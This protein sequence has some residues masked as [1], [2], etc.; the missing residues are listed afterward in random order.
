MPLSLLLAVSLK[1][2]GLLAVNLSRSFPSQEATGQSAWK[3]LTA[4]S[5]PVAP[6]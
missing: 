2:C 3:G 6:M 5:C 1:A 4:S